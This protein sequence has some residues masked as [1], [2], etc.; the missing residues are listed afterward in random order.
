MKSIS[1]S[2][3]TSPNVT[4]LSIAQG[5]YNFDKQFE[6]TGVHSSE[7]IKLKNTLLISIDYS[8]NC[9]YS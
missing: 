9:L 2:S 6:C 3:F 4:Y 1:F 5:S 8:R 7:L